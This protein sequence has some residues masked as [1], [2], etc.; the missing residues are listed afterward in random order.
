MTVGLLPSRIGT[1]PNIADML[2]EHPQPGADAEQQP[3]ETFV[4]GNGGRRMTP[5]QIA[6]ERALAQQQMQ[7]GADYSPVQH[8]TQGVARVAQGAVGGFK[9]RAARR[10]G[11][12]NAAASADIARLLAAGDKGSGDFDAILTG[13]A[14]DPYIDP[15]VRNLAETEQK[16]RYEASQPQYFN[17][18]NDRVMFDPKTQQ[19]SVLYQGQSDAE[20]YAASLG[21]QPGT[22]EF[23]TA[24][25]DYVLRANGPTAFG[26]DVDLEDA[27]QGNRETLE[28]VRYRNRLSLRQTPTYGQTHPR[29]PQPR[30]GGG[31]GGGRGPT[32][33]S[34]VIAPILAKVAAGK[35]LT[36]AEQQAYSMY[37]PGRGGSGGSQGSSAP[38]T[39]TDP[40]TGKKVQ[41]NGSAWVPVG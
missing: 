4:W 2:V 31:G 32:T 5:A 17:S 19:S 37:R 10:A 11:D 35:P 1:A 9:D 28:G 18:G 33:M 13:A 39:A 8:W 15:V 21:Y 22:P 14:A 34:A 20:D 16:R 30:G 29:T 12:A 3:A 25:Q 6:V 41:W 7:T 26:Y 27:R 38:R 24:M 40:K 36:P 23:S